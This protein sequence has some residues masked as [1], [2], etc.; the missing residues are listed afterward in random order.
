MKKQ[1]P[2]SKSLDALEKDPLSS[3]EIFECLEVG[4]VKL[5]VKRLI[6]PYRLKWNG[7]E[8][9]TELIYT[10]EENV[11]DSSEPEALNLASMIAAQVALNYGL[12][13][14]SMVFHGVFDDIDRRFIRDMAENTAREIYVKKFLEPNSF[15]IGE[16]ARLQPVKK[17]KYLRA[18]IEFRSSVSGKFTTKWHLWPTDHQRHCIL[19]SGGKDSLL[20]F[21][22]I[23]EIKQEVHPIFVNESGRHWFSA[24]NAYRYF[25]EHIPNTARVWVNS[26]RLFTWMLARMPFIRKNFADVRFF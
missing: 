19:S 15:L 14:R 5:E 21:G 6:A 2:P 13:C 18:V 8:E 4:P 23:D 20:S 25:K 17:Q 3:L 22:L 26:D 24:L 1:Q 7:K 16:A 12:F 11:F 9:Q 10:Y